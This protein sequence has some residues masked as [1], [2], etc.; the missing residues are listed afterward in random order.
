MPIRL[1][2]E[3]PVTEGP[4]MPRSIRIAIPEVNPGIYLIE[5]SAEAPGRE[6]LTVRKEIEVW[7][8]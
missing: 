4:Y 2:W 7:A 3:E 5:L 8:F 6:P 1:R